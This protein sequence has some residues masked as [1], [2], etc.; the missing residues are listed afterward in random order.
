MRTR[1]RYNEEERRAFAYAMR[2]ARSRV[3][4][5]AYDRATRGAT[6][7][8]FYEELRAATLPGLRVE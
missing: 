5:T 2:R 1:E 3:Y 4:V 7:P 6:A 8:E